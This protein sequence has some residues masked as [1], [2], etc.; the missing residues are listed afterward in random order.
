[1]LHFPKYCPL[2]D[3]NLLNKY[4]GIAVHY[5]CQY[6]RYQ[7]FQSSTPYMISY[8]HFEFFIYKND[9][10]LQQ[11]IIKPIQIFSS[12][13]ECTINMLLPVSNNKIETRFYFKELGVRKT[14]ITITDDNFKEVKEKIKKFMVFS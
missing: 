1:M 6:G 5:Y 10:Y 11:F 12:N 4:N 8:P 13:N 14:P 2:C 9:E 7:I 3:S